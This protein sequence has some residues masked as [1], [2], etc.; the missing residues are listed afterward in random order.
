MIEASNSF[1]VLEFTPNVKKLEVSKELKHEKST[2]SPKA[3]QYEE[4]A[5]R[6]KVQRS[7]SYDSKENPSPSLG[8]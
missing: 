7:S 5:C 4:Q 2:S 1:S 6:P 8:L 3:Y